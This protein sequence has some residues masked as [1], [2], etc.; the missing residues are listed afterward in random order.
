MIHK[1]NMNNHQ[2]VEKK[3]NDMTFKVST[4]DDEEEKS[5]N[6]DLDFISK[7]FMK[8]IKLEKIK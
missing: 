7:K 6:E 5:E 2:E 8:Y 4:I 1:I 3:S